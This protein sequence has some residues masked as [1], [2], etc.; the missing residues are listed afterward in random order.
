MMYVFQQFIVKLIILVGNITATTTLLLLSII[1]TNIFLTF[2]SLTGECSEEGRDAFIFFL[3]KNISEGGV[4]L[5]HLFC[6]N[7][8]ILNTCT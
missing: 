6:S 4:D 3:K 5:I 7:L 8:W 2:F 1:V